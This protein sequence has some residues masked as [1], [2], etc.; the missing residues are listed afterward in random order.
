MHLSEQKPTNPKFVLIK[1]LQQSVKHAL[2]SHQ[3]NQK[4]L[5]SLTNTCASFKT[6]LVYDMEIYQNLNKTEFQQIFL[7]LLVQIQHTTQ[8]NNKN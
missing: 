1:C 5:I 7:E 2:S 4:C 6:L 3:I 8:R